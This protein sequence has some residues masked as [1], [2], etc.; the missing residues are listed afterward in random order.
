LAVAFI[1]TSR[2]FIALSY[3]YDDSGAN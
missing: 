3:Q 1:S 2:V